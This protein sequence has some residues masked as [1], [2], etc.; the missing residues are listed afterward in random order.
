MRRPARSRAS[1]DR[2]LAIARALAVERRRRLEG[3]ARARDRA[4]DRPIS[5]P[6]RLSN[7]QDFGEVLRRRG[8]ATKG[9]TG[10]ARPSVPSIRA[11]FFPASPPAI[12]TSPSRANISARL[13][14]TSA[15][16]RIFRQ[17]ALLFEQVKAHTRIAANRS[18]TTLVSPFQRHFRPRFENRRAWL[19]WQTFLFSTRKK[20]REARHSFFSFVSRHIAR[21]REPFTMPG[22]IDLVTGKPIKNK[23]R[24]LLSALTPEEKAAQKAARAAEKEAKRAAKKSGKTKGAAADGDGAK[25]DAV[26]DVS[27]AIAKLTAGAVREPELLSGQQML[28][29]QKAVTGVLASNPGER[30]QDREVFGDRRRPAAAGRR[31]AGAERRHALRVHRPERQRQDQRFERHRATRDS[32]ARPHRHVPPARRGGARRAHRGGGG[33]GP[34]H[35][36]DRAPGGGA[37]PYH[38]KQRRGGRA[39]GGDQRST[40]GARPRHVRV[41]GE[42]DPQRARVLQRDRPDG[43]R[44]EGHVRRVAHARLARQGALRGADAVAVGRAHEPFGPGSLRVARSTSA[45]TRSACWWSATRRISSTRCATRSCGCTTAT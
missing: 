42:E 13:R 41:R 18:S 11:R 29:K 36:G 12:E 44:H 22:E 17:A 5:T 26:E 37:G 32:G 10:A 33:G 21:A 6:V 9:D 2:E 43:T 45:T 16:L 23:E 25:A 30:H 28:A 34:R 4:K 7:A 27:D 15:T 38:R 20:R 19:L 24:E 14:V 31:D 39:A 35:R 8:V 40:R 1:S 3:S